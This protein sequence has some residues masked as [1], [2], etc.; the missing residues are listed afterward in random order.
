MEKPD[1]NTLSNSGKKINTEP[2]LLFKYRTLNKNNEQWIK[3][4]FLKNKIYFPSPSKF[5]DP[6]DCKVNFSFKAS[7]REWQNYLGELIKRKQ[8]NWSRAKR[9]Q[10]VAEK[11][12]DK[13][14]LKDSFQNNIINS[15]QKNVDS[16]GV[17]CLSERFDD[18]LM[19]SHYSD[20]HKGFCIGFKAGS[21]TPFFGEAQRVVYQKEY[22]EVNFLEDPDRIVD[23]ILL[24]KSHHWKYEC[25]WRI[26]KQYDGPGEYKFP[27]DLL[28]QIILGCFITKDNKGQII[29]WSKQ[30]KKPPNLFQAIK[31]ENEYGLEII[32][33]EFS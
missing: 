24:T 17:F 18:I 11:T 2:N 28:D 33:L 3:N 32:P 23:A 14:Y 31:R 27:E 21:K 19:W 29:E 7:K 16:A 30:R 5:N 9:R 22:P 4:I 1:I 10:W 13:I 26:F 6:F 20:G 25:E 12:N 8:P 15:M